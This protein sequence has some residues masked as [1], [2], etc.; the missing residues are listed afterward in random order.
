[1]TR[2]NMAMSRY[3]VT[4]STR[5]RSTWYQELVET[6]M[7]LFLLLLHVEHV[8]VMRIV[9]SKFGEMR[10]VHGGELSFSMRVEFEMVT[11]V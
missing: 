2:S 4:S 9:M 3:T 7:I 5:L 11:V 10:I 1:M 6:R 8:K